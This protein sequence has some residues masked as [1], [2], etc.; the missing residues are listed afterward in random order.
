MTLLGALLILVGGAGAGGALRAATA[1]RRPLDLLAALA[2]PLFVACALVGGVLCLSP[3]F[4]RS[5]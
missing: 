1:R 5:P 3:G 4:L 2:G